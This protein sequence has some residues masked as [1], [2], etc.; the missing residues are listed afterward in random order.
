MPVSSWISATVTISPRRSTF[1]TIWRLTSLASAGMATFFIDPLLLMLFNLLSVHCF[2][3]IMKNVQ[4]K[5]QT[6][7][8]N[9]F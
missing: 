8:Q 2:H 9:T 7:L 3:Y 4:E 6:P 1:I 5:V